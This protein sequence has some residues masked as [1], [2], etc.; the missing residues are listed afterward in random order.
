[1]SC[2]SLKNLDKTGHRAWKRQNTKH[3]GMKAWLQRNATAMWP[4]AC[5]LRLLLKKQTYS[6]V[7][8]VVCSIKTSFIFLFDKRVPTNPV[9][10]GRLI[11]DLFSLPFGKRVRIPCL[12]RVNALADARS[13]SLDI[14]GRQPQC[15]LFVVL[16]L[17]DNVVLRVDI[18]CTRP[19][20][21]NKSNTNSEV[22]YL[23]IVW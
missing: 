21:Q 8:S 15:H 22:R 9:I 5:D 20:I 1:M 12:V 10:Q 11:K 16:L 14:V 7:Q 13:G 3:T 4:I 17:I 23:S 19:N 6:T 18:L 2:L